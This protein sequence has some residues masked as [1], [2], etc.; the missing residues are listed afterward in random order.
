MTSEIQYILDF[1]KLLINQINFSI[2][3]SINWTSWQI[4]TETFSLVYIKF[5]WS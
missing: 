2:L 3:S 5:T 4:L 1:Y